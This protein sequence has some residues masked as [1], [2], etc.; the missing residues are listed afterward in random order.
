[1]PSTLKVGVDRD[2]RRRGALAAG[3]GLGLGKPPVLLLAFVWLTGAL[4]DLVG[5]HMRG[6]GSSC[7]R[8]LGR[9]IDR[10]LGLKVPLCLSTP[11]E[12]PIPPPA[13][14][15]MPTHTSSL[16]FPHPIPNRSQ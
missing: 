11:I 12:S 2:G 13:G 16:H 4:G 3:G 5:A 1:M 9:S 15:A 14:R 8:A 6:K 7:V 10:L